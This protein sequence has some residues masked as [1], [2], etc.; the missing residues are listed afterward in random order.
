M[1]CGKTLKLFGD[2]GQTLK[3]TRL[4]IGHQRHLIVFLLAAVAALTARI[5]LF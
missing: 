4:V 3:V 5:S 1:R 2:H